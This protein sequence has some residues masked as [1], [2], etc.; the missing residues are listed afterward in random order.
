MEANQTL[1][2][3]LGVR[4]EE[5]IHQP[6]SHFVERTDQDRYYL[7]SQ[8]AFEDHQRQ[9][10]NIRMV[11]GSGEKIVIRLESLIAHEDENKLWVML[12]DI[13]ELQRIEKEAQ[14][15]SALRELRKRVNDQREQER[16]Q[17]A[18]DLHDGPMQGLIALTYA[19]HE[20]QLDYPD[21]ALAPRLESLQTDLKEQIAALR[22]YAM[23]IRPPLLSKFGLE[24]T[25]RAHAE[26][27]QQKHPHICI[28][29]E[30]HQTGALLAETTSL[31]LFRIYQEALSNILKHVK[32]PNA[33]VRVSLDKDENWV[34]LEIQD[35][36][37]GFTMP[38]QWMDLVRE[39][40]LGLVGM[41]ERAEALDGQMEIQSNPGEGTRVV[42]IIP[43][44]PVRKGD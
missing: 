38:E 33:Q 4:R 7:H 17:I 28:R 3:L 11:K 31:A 30:M 25:I 20:I 39:G 19:I 1:A 42:V 40:H 29:L 2:V 37:P 5:L 12:S 27:F 43:L 18:H 44:E 26:I 16:Y 36:G 10:S 24:Q 8:R 22:T 14:E 32:R 34:R 41:R 35:N 9:I 21:P 6:L 15:A 23:E 13:T